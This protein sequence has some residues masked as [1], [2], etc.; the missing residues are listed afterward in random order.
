MYYYT[1]KVSQRVKM[2]D[3]G[4]IGQWNDKT[5]LCFSNT[6]I[7][8]VYKRSDRHLTTKELNPYLNGNFTFFVKK[9]KRKKP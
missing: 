4:D 3:I 8:T 9:K 2:A 6:F 1:T 7:Y 5:M